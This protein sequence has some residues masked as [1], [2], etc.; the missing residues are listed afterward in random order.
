M[1]LNKYFLMSAVL[2]ATV[3]PSML[4]SQTPASTAKPQTGKNWIAYVGTY[5]TAAGKGIYSYHYNPATGAMTSMAV[6]ATTVS[7]SFMV[8]SPNGKF[9]YAVNEAKR[10]N[11]RTN[12][13]SVTA[14]KINHE[15]GALDELNILPSL[16][17]DP[18]H[19][20]IDH[21]GRWLI[22]ANYTGGNLAVIPL[23]ADGSLDI[24][25]RMYQHTGASGVDPARQ[26]APHVHSV[27]FSNDDKFLYSSDLGQ[28]TVYIYA[29]DTITG[30]LVEHGTAKTAPGA[31]PRHLA[32]SPDRKFAYGVNEL[33]AT[34]TAYHA[35][36]VQAT[37]EPFESLSTLPADFTGA[38][39]GAEIAMS[40]NGRFLYASNRGH[41]SIATFRVSPTD[42]KLTA[43]GYTPTRGKTP[44]FFTLDPA[45]THLIA[46]NQDS[47]SL[48]IFTVNQQ[49]GALTP[50]GDTLSVPN[51]ASV[52][53][54]RIQ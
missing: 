53:F 50:V 9:L 25:T 42:G 14:F 23:H 19:L 6:A 39:S 54:A 15:T 5:T 33:S 8:V 34:V 40:A 44:R 1:R 21:T 49:T 18:C 47:D 10:F 35:N 38:K 31:G 20:A 26:E 24:T 12:S 45:G 52:V 48:A 17:A 32:F 2:I 13:G 22:V 51:P 11:G 37:L 16:G 7:P 28:D 29:F 30:K 43:A 46:A 4:D 27:Y 3:V 41:D 36:A